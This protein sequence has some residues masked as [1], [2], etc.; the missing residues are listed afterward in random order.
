MRVSRKDGWKRK[1]REEEIVAMCCDVINIPSPTGEEFEMGRYMRSAFEQMGLE[2]TWQEVEEGRANAPRK[3]VLLVASDAH[4]L[5]VARHRRQ[6]EQFFVFP[7]P[8]ADDLMEWPSKPFQYA[9]A[10]R[11]GIPFPAER[12]ARP[13]D[14]RHVGRCTGVRAEI[15]RERQN[16]SRRAR[17]PLA[18]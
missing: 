15:L 1:L 17:P 13:H 2:V 5:F 9:A 16:R 18:R 7:L 14:K 3:G 8:A 10:T 12:A 6:L 11:A 4:W